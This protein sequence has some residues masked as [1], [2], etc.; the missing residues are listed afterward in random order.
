M[1]YTK[2]SVF[3]L[4]FLGEPIEKIITEDFD[5]CYLF[6]TKEYEDN[7]LTVNYLNNIGN[8]HLDKRNFH[9]RKIS[10]NKNTMYVFDIPNEYNK[11]VRAIKDG[12]YS[13]ISDASKSLITNFWG[14]PKDGILA[15]ILT[16]STDS[17][18]RLKEKGFNVDSHSRTA[19]TFPRMR[20]RHE[21]LS[22]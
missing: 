20:F 7:T 15:G 21:T 18:E 6:N 2:S 8:P 11:V 4:P 13:T 9:K 5:N 16:C 19:E 17:K 3:L 12:N 22:L 1:R 10:H 14:A